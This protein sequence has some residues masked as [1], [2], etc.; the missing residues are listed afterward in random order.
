MHESWLD[1]DDAMWIDGKAVERESRKA[2][3]EVE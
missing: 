3:D 1:E 2:E